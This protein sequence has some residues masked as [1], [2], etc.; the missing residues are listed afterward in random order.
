[1]SVVITTSIDITATRA[2]VWSVL[3]DFAA[4][5]EWS[6]F[7]SID[8][9]P[10]VGTKLAM[11][12]PGFAFSSRVA[13]ATVDT[14]L[15]WEAR[16]ITKGIFL[17][18]HSFTLSDNADGT[19]RLTNTETFSGVLVKPFEGIFANNHNEGGY[20]PFNRALKARVEARR[21]ARVLTNA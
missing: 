6:N 5:G 19:T 12:M 9:V 2:E 15:C 11:K 3:T 4:Y 18:S 17:G 20:G 7:R 16:I 1:M 21:S 13:V 8:G 10:V 14:E